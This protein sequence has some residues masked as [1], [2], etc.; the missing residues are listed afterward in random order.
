MNVLEPRSLCILWCN[1][2]LYVK[3]VLVDQMELPSRGYLSTFFEFC[4]T[5][6]ISTQDRTWL[7]RDIMVLF[8]DFLAKVSFKIKLVQTKNCRSGFY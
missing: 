2:R 4:S 8:L 7:V 6:R 5:R 1:D 3:S